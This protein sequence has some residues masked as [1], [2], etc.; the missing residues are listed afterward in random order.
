MINLQIFYTRYNNIFQLA[1]RLSANTPE[2]NQAIIA[3]IGP[4]II[5]LKSDLEQV[6]SNKEHHIEE[7][8][9]LSS[10]VNKLSN[11]IEA[12]RSQLIKVQHRRDY[13]FS[14]QF[15]QSLPAFPTKNE[16][17]IHFDWI[18][19]M[20]EACKEELK[21]T[22]EDPLK[23]LKRIESKLKKIKGM[24]DLGKD[25]TVEKEKYL[26][27][28]NA[29]YKDLDFLKVKEFCPKF[30]RYFSDNFSNVDPDV[31]LINKIIEF[32]N[33]YS[34]KEM[35]D[36][37]NA[38]YKKAYAISYS[39][40]LKITLRKYS[41]KAEQ[42]FQ[43]IKALSVETTSFQMMEKSVKAAIEEIRGFH[44]EIVSSLFSTKQIETLAQTHPFVW[45]KIVDLEQSFF[46]K[47][48]EYHQLLTRISSTP[49]DYDSKFKE[50]IAL[51]DK[52]EIDFLLDVNEET[53]G[54]F[55]E[56]GDQLL[57]NL[58]NEVGYWKQIMPTSE[59]YSKVKADLEKLKR[60]GQRI[61]D[62]CFFKKLEEYFFSKENHFFN[63]T[64]N[65][66]GIKDFMGE[67]KAYPV[68]DKHH[69]KPLDEECLKLRNKIYK[70]INEIKRDIKNLSSFNILLKKLDFLENDSTDKNHQESILLRKKIVGFEC[71]TLFF[72][73]EDN[74]KIEIESLKRKINNIDLKYYEFK[75][76]TLKQLEL[77]RDT[78]NNKALLSDLEEKSKNIIGELD[79]LT[80]QTR[81]QHLKDKIE[82][83]K[84]DVVENQTLLQIQTLIIE[85]AQ[86]LLSLEE[87]YQRL[88][89]PQN[90]KNLALN[91]PEYPLLLKDLTEFEKGV[92]TAI[93]MAEKGKREDYKG[94]LT[95]NLNRV[96][97]LIDGLKS[98]SQKFNPPLIT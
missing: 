57:S 94:I 53:L 59:I 88:T 61:N 21:V 41:E 49:T 60:C 92:R 35:T 12:I 40:T 11:K 52:I 43:M 91:N 66:A 85:L 5:L 25:F 67:L 96:G 74:F 77:T 83:L 23:K 44:N 72:F 27:K 48:D 32:L 47:N 98:Y 78:S 58:S 15:F 39:A 81:N 7:V 33:H 82:R 55:N 10:E 30:E 64:T 75:A 13:E 65:V 69:A 24:L 29:L 86:K 28:L 16:A 70:K 93:E 63:I 45:Q 14:E 89:N 2:E 56:L 42:Q 87:S 17:G 51:A 95:G 54:K 46:A 80:N 19:K 1:G 68:Q 84:A 76:D 20:I 34:G 6:D 26:N 18:E 71:F 9:H 90:S 37:Q 4:H 8:E 73:G 31:N 50:F 97:I 38:I 79:Q 22:S 3:A 62:F 36:E